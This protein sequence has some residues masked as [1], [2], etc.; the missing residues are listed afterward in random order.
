MVPENIYV[1]EVDISYINKQTSVMIYRGSV[2]ITTVLISS[3][4]VASSIVRTIEHILARCCPA[5]TYINTYFIIKSPLV[6]KDL[7]DTF[8][9]YGYRALDSMVR[10]MKL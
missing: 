9:Y 10:E 5:A 4:P 7:R 6:H 2:Y 3:D 1:L 8:L